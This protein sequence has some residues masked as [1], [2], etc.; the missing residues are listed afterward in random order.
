M[1]LEVQRQAKGYYLQEGERKI[2]YTCATVQRSLDSRAAMA[3]VEQGSEMKKDS[4][5]EQGRVIKLALR[6]PQGYLSQGSGPIQWAR[7]P[8]LSIRDLLIS[9]TIRVGLTQI[10]S[11]LPVSDLGE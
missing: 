11:Q 3:Q 9:S 8:G 7:G 4:V 5:L 2:I 6:Y 1:Y 10:S